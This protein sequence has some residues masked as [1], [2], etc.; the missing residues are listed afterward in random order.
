M[1]L[2]FR[3][4]PKRKVEKGHSKKKNATQESHPSTKTTTTTT[5]VPLKALLQQ[6]EHQAEQQRLPIRDDNS[7]VDMSIYTTE[8]KSTV[9][10]DRSMYY[11]AMKNMMMG[12]QADEDMSVYTST[13]NTGNPYWF[14]INFQGKQQTRPQQAASPA[15]TAPSTP[16]YPN[17]GRVRF[18]D[19]DEADAGKPMV[20]KNVS[21]EKHTGPVDLDELSDELDDDDDDY[22]DEDEKKPQYSDSSTSSWPSEEKETSTPVQTTTKKANSP[23]APVDGVVQNSQKREEAPTRSGPVDV[24]AVGDEDVEKEDEYGFEVYSVASSHQDDLKTRDVKKTGVHLKEEDEDSSYVWTDNEEHQGS[25]VV[26]RK[27]SSDDAEILDQTYRDTMRSISSSSK[28][29]MSQ[30]KVDTNSGVI[31]LT[32]DELQKHSRI[33]Q[34]QQPHPSSSISGFDRWKRQQEQQIRR[35][36]RM[37][38]FA[39]P[40]KKQVAKHPVESSEGSS[41]NSSRN[42]WKVERRSDETSTGSSRSS[43]DRSK[44]CRWKLLPSFPP[45]THSRKEADGTKQVALPPRMQQ[46]PQEHDLME[47]ERIQRL[48]ERELQRQREMNLKPAITTKPATSSPTK[49]Y[50]DMIPSSTKNCEIAPLSPTPDSMVSSIQSHSVTV[51]SPCTICNAAERSHIAMPCMHFHFCKSCVDDILRAGNPVCPVCN[52]ANVKFGKVHTG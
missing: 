40:A 48:K 22:G 24:D 46:P 36:E 35:M 32:Q 1:F 31:L 52:T 7:S 47:Q 26:E 23:T 39:P 18:Q 33:V 19:D 10:Y 2:P 30:K 3:H 4:G 34:K 44:R 17:G 14:D 37:Q 38:K 6:Q 25:P 15:S 20:K 42:S 29:P 8:S 43:K 27:L 9:Q 50:C 45:R 13:N 49:P 51:L 21:S 11:P 12:K 41:N 5:T 16:D 28:P